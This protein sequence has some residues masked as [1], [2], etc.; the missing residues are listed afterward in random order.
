VKAALNE[1]LAAGMILHSGW[2]AN[3]AFADPMWLR[4]DTHRSSYARQR[5]TR[6]ISGKI[7]F[8]Q[9]PDFDAMLW[10]QGSS[11]TQVPKYGILISHTRLRQGAQGTQLTVVNLMA[12]GLERLVTV[13]RVPFGK[14]LH[15]ASSGLLMMNPPYD[16]RLRVEDTIAFYQ[17]IANRL[18]SALGRMERLGDILQP[19]CTQTLRPAPFQKDYPVQR[20][21]RVLFP[22]FRFVRRIKI[23]RQQ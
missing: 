18:E 22:A 2:D 3:S 5:N 14:N 4:N 11:K 15:P 6:S 21:P 8:F 9:W 13:E 20:S 23:R 7:R 17:G 16:E 1:V 10:N 19:G 12:A